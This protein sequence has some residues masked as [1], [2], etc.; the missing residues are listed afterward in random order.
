MA[1]AS[2]TMARQANALG[3]QARTLDLINQRLGRIEEHL[4]IEE[5]EAEE[6]TLAGAAG[7]DQI[8]PFQSTDE[9][10]QG[11]NRGTPDNPPIKTDVEATTSADP[12]EDAPGPG[13]PPPYPQ[14]EPLPASTAPIRT[15]PGTNIPT[16]TAPP[17]PGDRP[18]ARRKAGRPKGKS[19]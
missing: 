15:A 5:P 13:Q 3:D 8:Q 16:R 9:F 11:D 17:E 2:R 10:G 4:G 12:S 19:K 1:R 14:G 6:G 18:D 7:E